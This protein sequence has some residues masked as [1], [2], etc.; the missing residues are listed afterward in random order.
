[1][2]YQVKFDGQ[3]LLQIFQSP[4]YL[5]ACFFPPVELKQVS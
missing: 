1:M 4:D 5:P 2:A 3:S